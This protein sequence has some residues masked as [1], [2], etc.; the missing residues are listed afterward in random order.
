MTRRPRRNHSVA[1]RRVALAAVQGEETLALNADS[2]A[3]NVGRRAASERC[4]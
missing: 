1:L 3:V 4:A 2:V